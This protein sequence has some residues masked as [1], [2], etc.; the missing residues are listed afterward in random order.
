VLHRF[1]G[2]SDGYLPLGGVI[3]DSQGNLYGTTAVGGGTGCNDSSGCGTVF[4]VTVGGTE[5]VLYAFEGGNDG[6]GPWSSPV[7]DDSG[8]F[9]GT[10]AG[11][12]SSNRGT[13]FKL[14][15]DG[16]ESVLYAFTYGSDGY[17]PAA[18]LI[19]DGGGNLYGTTSDGGTNCGGGGCGTVFELTPEGKEKVLYSFKKARGAH[20]A[21][22]LLMGSNGTLYGTAPS[23]G[24]YKDGVVFKVKE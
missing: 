24:K 7:I 16:T 8:N 2:G 23:G 12:G 11:G 3:L 13:V 5:T 22:G 6:A 17:F 19:E 1:E 10:T 14:A 20:P 15:P 4:K 21:A 9:Y 18:G